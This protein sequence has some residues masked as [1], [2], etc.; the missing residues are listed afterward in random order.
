M[1]IRVKKKRLSGICYTFAAIIT[2][3]KK[4]MSIDTYK[5]TSMEEPMGNRYL[6]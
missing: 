6:C 3:H 2:K 4:I 1:I 5:L